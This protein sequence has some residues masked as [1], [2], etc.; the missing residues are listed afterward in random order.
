MSSTTTAAR[1][2]GS[3]RT[4]APVDTSIWNKRGE[5]AAWGGFHCLG[6]SPDRVVVTI[7]SQ[8]IIQALINA[9]LLF[10]HEGRGPADRGRYVVSVSRDC[11]SQGKAV[12]CSLAEKLNVRCFDRSLVEDVAKAIGVEPYLLTRL[13]ENGQGLRTNWLENLVT[14]KSE[15]SQ[16]HRKTL[17]NVVLGIGRCGGVIVG[18]GANFILEGTQVFRVRIVAPFDIRVRNYIRRHDLDEEMARRRVTE[19]DAQRAGYT[20]SLFGRDINDPVAYDMVLNSS[21]LAPQVM[22]EI[23][24]SALPHLTALPQGS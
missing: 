15:F 21:R 22:V 10:A 23:I 13:D 19:I 1:A 20:Q 3:V 7:D 5:S 11:G 2:A 17:F 16:M 4:N 18:R 12:A 9:E 14:R 6:P 24:A 8:V